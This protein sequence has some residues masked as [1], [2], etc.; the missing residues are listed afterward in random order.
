MSRKRFAG[1][2]EQEIENLIRSKD[3]SSSKKATKQAVKILR[4]FCSEKE[5]PTN[6]ENLTKTQL[7]E[8]LRNFY[9]NARK[10]DGSFY[11]KNTL[12]GIRYGLSRYLMAEKKVS[13]IDDVEFGS[14][15]QVFSASIAELKKIGQ[16]KV[17]HHPE[18]TKEDLQKLYL[19]FD[20]NTPKGLQD[21][22][23]FDIMF[24]LVRR[25]RENLREQTKNSFAIAVDA[26]NRRYIHQAMDEL[27]KNHRENDDPFDATTDGRVYEKPGPLCPVKSFE[28]YLSKLHPDLEFLWQR[29]K[30]KVDENDSCWYQKSPIGKNTIGSFMKKLSNTVGLSRQYT[31]HSIRTTAVTVLDHSSFEARHIMRVSGHKSESSIRSYSRRLP[32][33]KQREISDVL[34]SACGFTPAVETAF[35]KPSSTSERVNP[36]YDPIDA[37]HLDADLPLTSSQYE[38]ALE[39][40]RDSHL[41]QHS[42]PGSPIMQSTQSTS[43]SLENI[44]FGPGCFQNCNVTFKFCK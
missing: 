4:E 39:A 29:P 38:C 35:S 9:A 5:I 30:C 36:I 15:N 44:C 25:G 31:N 27:D 1:R 11:T 7:N 6:F 23:M 8:L 28:L 37:D 19:S 10:A 21:K 20:L 42:L 16:A 33:N 24:F 2:T 41:P 40:L 26:Q 12:N 22:C 14:S 18:I 32:E 43:N 17:S 34:A 13:I 3:S